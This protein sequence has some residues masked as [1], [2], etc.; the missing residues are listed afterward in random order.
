MLLLPSPWQIFISPW[1]ILEHTYKVK[2]IRNLYQKI[3]TQQQ[4]HQYAIQYYVTQSGDLANV[5]VCCH[6][7]HLK[8]SGLAHCNSIPALFHDAQP[9]SSDRST[10]QIIVVTFPS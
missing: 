9:V 3:V 1:L 7:T 2:L 5:S 10:R 4:L 6:R 8:I